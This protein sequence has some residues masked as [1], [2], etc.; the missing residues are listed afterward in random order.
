M[1]TTENRSLMPNLYRLTVARISFTSRIYGFTG[2]KSLDRDAS[3]F[4][5]EKLQTVREY[6]TPVKV[7]EVRQFLGLVGYYKK[8]IKDFCRIAEPLTN[9]TRKDVPFVW[10]EECNDAFLLLKQ[11]LLEPPILAYPHFDG[12]PFI[13]QT[14]ASLKGLGFI[15]AQQHDGRERVISYGGRALHK[16]EKKYSITELEALAVVE[17]IKKY[18][19][20][21]QH[22][23]KFKVVTDHC[24]LK[25]LFSGNH[26]GGRLARWSLNLQA[27][28]FEV[29]HIRGKNNGNADAL[30]RINRVE[31]VCSNCTRG[32]PAE[33]SNLPS[34][35]T[36]IESNLDNV[37]VDVIQSPTE[38][39]PRPAVD[40][41]R[42]LRYKHGKR[43][44]NGQVAPPQNPQPFP[45]ELDL[46]KFKQELAADS[47]ANSM[48]TYLVQDVLPADSVK[49]RDIVI[50]SDQY[51]VHD[52]LLYHIWHT[53][54]KRHIPERNVIRLYIPKKAEPKFNRH[55][56]ILIE[57]PHIFLNIFTNDMQL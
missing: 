10:A 43:I 48:M 12:T 11:K 2:R 39:Q 9:L 53:P 15:L 34:E 37:A 35:S 7:S 14:D 44:E 56:F 52:E 21:L 42:N 22:S 31:P 17:G 47:F 1:E 5:T 4:N 3:H 23:V 16:A 36:W 57:I 50:Q 41:V 26:S 20:Y 49:A 8:F 38:T 24:A 6:P 45:H 13:L 40:V 18:R 25:W 28:D 32:R 30:S 55:F 27:Y 51:F 29:V 33:I 54:A 19:P 46:A